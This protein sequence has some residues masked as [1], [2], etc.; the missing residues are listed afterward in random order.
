LLATSNSNGKASISTANL[1]GETNLKNQIAPSLTR[2]Y[3]ADQLM[4]IKAQIECENPNPDLNG[5]VGRITV[6][7]PKD[8]SITSSPIR[9]ASR[10]TLTFQVFLSCNVF[11]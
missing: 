8:E 2:K 10:G 3:R 7:D 1:D 5:F 6:E 9:K 11:F 4:D